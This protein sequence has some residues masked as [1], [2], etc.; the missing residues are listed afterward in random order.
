M[1]ETSSRNNGKNSPRS[2]RYSFLYTGGKSIEEEDD[3]ESEGEENNQHKSDI[4][5]QSEDEED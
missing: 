1:S 5:S 4:K 3:D 2:I